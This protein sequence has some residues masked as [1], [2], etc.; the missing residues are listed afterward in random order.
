MGSSRRR[1][2]NQSTHSKVAYSTASR[3]RQGPRRQITSALYSPLMV[4]AI[5]LS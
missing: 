3:L 1:L 4:S 2:L 5:A